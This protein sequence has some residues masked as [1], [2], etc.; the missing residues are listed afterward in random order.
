MRG[1]AEFQ[2]CT[3]SYPYSVSNFY[4]CFFFMKKYKRMYSI[5][6]KRKPYTGIHNHLTL[7]LE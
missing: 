3:F 1:N 7:Y 6:R 2:V 5:S 4:V